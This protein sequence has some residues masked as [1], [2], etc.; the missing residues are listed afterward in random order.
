MLKRKMKNA[1]RSQEII[2]VF[3]K[4]GFSHILFRLGLTDR[5]FSTTDEA[6]DLNLYHVGKKLR[7]ALEQLGPTFVKLGQI[8]SGRRDLVPA[9]IAEELEKLQD[10]V[11]AF[12]FKDVRRIV[13][14]QLEGTLEEL[15]QEF[16]EEPLASASIGQVHRARLISGDL[17]A[18]KVQ[19]PNIQQQVETDLAILHDLAGFLEKNTGWAKAYHLRDLIYEFSHS[20]R[21]ELDYQLEARN[22]E[23][24]GRQFEKVA[25]IQVPRV[26]DE[27]ST[28]V[29]LTT[30]LITG[31]KVS[32]IKQLDEEGYDRQILAQRIADSMLSQVMEHGFFHGDPHPGN[33]FITPGNTVY[34][35]DFG[36]IGQLSKEMTYHFISLMLALQK[37]NIER[38]IDVFSAMDILDDDTN[39]DALY[40]DLQI[41]ERK[42]YE[43]SLTDL[44]L[45]DVFMEI[46]SIA[47]RHRI[48][49]PNEMAILSKVIITL[50]GVIS[51][52][53]PSLSIMKAIEAYSKKVFLKQFDPRRLLE[54]SWHTFAKNA[55]IVAEL[56]T[57]IKKAIRTIEKGKVDLDIG[58]KETNVIFRRFDKIANRL[59]FSIVLLA[60]SIL[61]VGLIVGSAI[62]GQTAMF[63]RL[64]LIEVG[65]VIATL[66]F[67]YLL[68]SIVRS[69]RI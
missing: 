3:L 12:P 23:R 48:R 50:E 56:P 36:M 20:L 29:L 16:E 40:R 44:Q 61:M 65:S 47:Y 1:Q 8:A 9:E 41:I 31:I 25:E 28:R 39:T 58:L 10:H 5:K 26:Y 18:V 35:I 17:V 22:A 45:S 27:Y 6:A 67:A 62:A 13:E 37:G 11:V 19:R 33:I 69:G 15:F 34:F 60:F 30:E 21:E 57:D 54:N 52:L 4:N 55:E 59:S 51:K 53:D 43:T 63:F 24:I 42:Y 2:N 7:T 46:F 64:P 68:V 49:L 32:N 14:Q 38:M 66:M